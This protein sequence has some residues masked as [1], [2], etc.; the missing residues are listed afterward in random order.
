MNERAGPIGEILPHQAPWN[1]GARLLLHGIRR[2]G[3]GGINDAHIANAMI[4]LFGLSFRRPLVLM[5]AMMAELSRA[6]TRSII[7]APSCCARMTGSEAVLV[8]AVAEAGDSPV[9]AHD[10]LCGLCGVSSC[11]GLLSSAQAVAQAFADL[12]HPIEIA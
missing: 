8:S 2:M 6:A 12:G 11:L 5:R 3:V 4:G 1:D 10:L 9:A 7:I